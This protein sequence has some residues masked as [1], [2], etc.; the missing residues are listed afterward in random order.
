MIVREKPGRYPEAMLGSCVC[1]PV[2]LQRTI[3][4]ILGYNNEIG[5]SIYLPHRD[6]DPRNPVHYEREV[7]NIGRVI[8]S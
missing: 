6:Q 3:L 5:I 2:P 1:C 8:S 7:V 4:A